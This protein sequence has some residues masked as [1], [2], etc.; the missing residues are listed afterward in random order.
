MLRLG[1]IP[2]RQSQ[3]INRKKGFWECPWNPENLYLNPSIEF[4]VT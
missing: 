3:E 4:S 1:S 2:R